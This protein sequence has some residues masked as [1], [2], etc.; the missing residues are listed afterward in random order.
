MQLETD[1][2]SHSQQL[3]RP[4]CDL[5]TPKHQIA[6]ACRSARHFWSPL[7]CVDASLSCDVVNVER[8][9][10]VTLDNCQHH[11]CYLVAS[12]ESELAV[13]LSRVEPSRFAKDLFA[14]LL[15]S[16]AFLLCHV[17]LTSRGKVTSALKPPMRMHVQNVVIHVHSMRSALTCRCPG[18]LPTMRMRAENE[19]WAFGNCTAVPKANPSAFVACCFAHRWRGNLFYIPAACNMSHSAAGPGVI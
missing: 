4:Y 7:P 18:R 15:H 5:D 17:F 2:V 9:Q 10:R 11:C 16:I 14:A 13:F 8:R 12:F 3:A 19:R 1:R 6:G